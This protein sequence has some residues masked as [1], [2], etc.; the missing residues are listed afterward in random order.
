MHCVCE[1]TDLSWTENWPVHSIP[2][3]LSAWSQTWSY[4]SFRSF[5]AHLPRAASSRAVRT[6]AEVLL[7]N[8]AKRTGAGDTVRHRWPGNGGKRVTSRGVT[9][10]S[11]TQTYKWR[12]WSP[13]RLTLQSAVIRSSLLEPYASRRTSN[14]LGWFVEAEDRHGK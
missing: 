8:V 1:P 12:E 10:L 5:S 9:A 3:A 6:H 13:H 7:G 14:I 11:A 4:I 2:K